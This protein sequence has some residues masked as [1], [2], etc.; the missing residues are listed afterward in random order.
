MNSFFAYAQLDTHRYREI[1][2]L[3]FEDFQ[4][5]QVFKHR[6]G[7]TLSQ[8]DNKNEALD[9][10]NS[11]QLHY[12]QN[13]ASKTE[14]KHCLGVSTL[15]LQNILGSTWKTFYKKDRILRFSSIAMTHPVFDGDTLY[16]QSTIVGIKDYPDDANVGLVQVITEG[17]NQKN[18]VVSKVEYDLLVYKKGKHPS[19]K[20]ESKKLSPVSDPRFQ[21]YR[22]LQDGSLME[23]VGLFYEDLNPAEIFEHRPGKTITESENLQHSLRSLDWNPMYTDFN[24]IKKNY[25]GK[26][27][28]NEHYFLGA[29]TAESARTFGRVVAN[30][31]WVNIELPL[32]LYVGDTFYGESEVIS[33]RESHSRPKQGIVTAKTRAYNQDGKLVLSY[34][35][36]FLIYKKEFNPFEAAGY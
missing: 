1:F 7:V 32:P 34:E 6:P 23:Q 18:E 17:I 28:I 9:T 27:R 16:S 29:A 22:Q 2:G 36:T 25:S 4:K 30:L 20:N 14:W 10:I 13:Y 8:Q 15:T 19:V 11:A 31:G 21:S 24:Y 26:H 33:K 5:G 12:D 35:R 3:D